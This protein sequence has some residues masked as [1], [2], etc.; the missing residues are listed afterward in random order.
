MERGQPRLKAIERSENL[1]SEELMF[2]SPFSISKKDFNYLREEILKLIK[3][4]SLV[5]KDSP[6]EEV[7]CLNFDLIWI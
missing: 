5:I 2:T 7:A 4:T 1:A 3:S 6:A